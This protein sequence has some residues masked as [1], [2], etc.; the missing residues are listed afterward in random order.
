M[1]MMALCPQSLL[2]LSQAEYSVYIRSRTWKRRSAMVKERDGFRCVLCNSDYLLEA[3]HR[4]YENLAS[5]NELAEIGD[6]CTLC[7][8]C[9]RHIHVLL[10]RNK[11]ANW[12]V[13]EDNAF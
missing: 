8:K 2:M 5:E 10:D 1:S 12:E 4:S 3:H 9:H 6:L 13:D 11:L 7:R